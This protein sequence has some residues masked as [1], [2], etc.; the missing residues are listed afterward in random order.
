MATRRRNSKTIGEYSWV[1]ESGDSAVQGEAAGLDTATGTIRPMGSSSTQIFVGFFVET[2]TGDGTKKVRVN[3]PD[4]VNAEWLA[5][6]T[7]P[8]DIGA[9]DI[10]SEVY[11]KDAKTVSTLSTSRSK[12]G[13][14]LDY[15]SS[16]NLVLVQGGTA[17]TGPAGAGSVY[18]SVADR[19]ALTAIGATSRADGQTVLVRDD[20]SLWRFIAA[21]SQTVDG[22]GMLVLAPDAGTGRWVRADKSFTLKLACSKDTTDAFA[23]CT[24]PEQMVLRL[25]G[26]PYWEVT[27]GFT[28]GTNSAI[29]M[30]ASAIATTKG[31]LL[32]GSG[33]QL[34]AVL[35]TAGVKAGTIGPLID[36]LAEIQAFF[37]KQAD[38][39]R[40]D[41]ITSTY[42]A[43]A[44]YIHVPVAID[45]VA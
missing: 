15:D 28:G 9:T 30:S 16:S 42:A 23:L 24:I 4:E 34:T 27:T 12:A 35:G 29:G 5:N 7:N 21:S 22:A 18:G 43:G 40:F 31:D 6:D 45:V 25:T 1:L 10:G 37:L 32:G 17:V 20:G 41:K 33:G 38:Y 8:N 14:V 2:L 19:T 3:V 36:T 26:M 13:R 11:A 39:L 44:G